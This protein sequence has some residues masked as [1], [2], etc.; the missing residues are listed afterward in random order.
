MAR[1]KKT[2]IEVIENPAEVKD[3]LI[4]E[5]I[6]KNYMPYVMTVII[7]R[8]I[9]EIDGFK[10]SHR[11]LL[12][13]MYKMGLLSGG[14]VKSAN[15][16]GATMQ[17]NPHG[18]QAIYDTI[19]DN[20]RIQCLILDLSP[21]ADLDKIFRPLENSRTSEM[22]LGKEKA[23]IKDRP[24]HASWLRIYAIKLEPGCYI[25][26]GGA[27]KLTRTMQEREHTLK[28][29]NKMEQVRNYLISNQAIDAD[30]FVDF[31]SEL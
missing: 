29:L 7:S 17:L 26:T 30:G 3:Q 13:T 10:P 28:E 31:L 27:I 4:T 24:Q 5:T 2:E 12:Y 19:D 22:L 20:Q 14:R 8:A 21:E 18:D 9:P 15:V 25:I 1:K 6:E 23:K 16:V 11:K